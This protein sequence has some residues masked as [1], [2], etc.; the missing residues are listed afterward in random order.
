MISVG[1][2]KDQWHKMIDSF[3]TLYFS[4]NSRY[5]LFIFMRD[6]KMKEHSYRDLWYDI[7]WNTKKWLNYVLSW[8]NYVVLSLCGIFLLLW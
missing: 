6:I 2:E 3:W 8:L 1:V 5:I 7:S 4:R